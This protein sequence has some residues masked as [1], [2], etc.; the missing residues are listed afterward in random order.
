VVLLSGGLDSSVLLGLAALGSSRVHA[1]SIYY[2]QRH[3]QEIACAKALVKQWD[4]PQEIVHVDAKI[5]KT[6]P[7]V[8]GPDELETGRTRTAI[9][10]GGVPRAYV[11]ARNTVFLSHGVSLAATLGGGE[12][13]LGATREDLAGFPDCRPGFLMAFNMMLLESLPANT[14]VRVSAPLA[15]LT[16]TDVARLAQRLGLAPEQTWSCYRPRKDD[17]SCGV[18]DACVIRNAALA[19]VG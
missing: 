11:P 1:L 16:K 10:S 4:I 19:E 14:M 13:L 8:G 6:V 12:V 9:A 5:W 2:G 15:N 3:M 17:T 18:C 7:L